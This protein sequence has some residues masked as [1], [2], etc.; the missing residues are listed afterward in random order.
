MSSCLILMYPWFLKKT[1][2][3]ARK[4]SFCGGLPI[5]KV[6][7]KK[8]CASDG[9]SA[10]LNRYGKSK[11][12]K[13]IFQTLLFSNWSSSPTSVADSPARRSRTSVCLDG[14]GHPWPD[15]RTGRPHPAKVARMVKK[16][17]MD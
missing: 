7:S 15:F 3:G 8:L 2:L 5:V 10:H 11:N 12:I 1:K 4:S 9:L 17:R 14:P 6:H 13:W 16:T